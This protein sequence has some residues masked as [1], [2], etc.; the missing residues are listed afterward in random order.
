MKRICIAFR[1]LLRPNKVLR[2]MRARAETAVLSWKARKCWILL[3]IV[4]P[5]DQNMRSIVQLG[6][7][8]A[9]EQKTYPLQQQR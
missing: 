8:L 7:R 1:G 2:E 3:K 9:A 4:L 5:N 6:T